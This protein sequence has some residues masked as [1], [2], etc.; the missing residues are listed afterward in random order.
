MYIPHSVTQGAVAFHVHF[1][2]YCPHQDKSDEYLVNHT[3]STVIYGKRESE[4]GREGGRERET[5]RGRERETY[6]L[7]RDRAQARQIFEVAA[8]VQESWAMCASV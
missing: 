5:E 1:D 7:R 6:A 2:L 3:R 8:P 4:G